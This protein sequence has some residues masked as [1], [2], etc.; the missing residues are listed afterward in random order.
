VIMMAVMK[1]GLKL[2]GVIGPPMNA[3]KPR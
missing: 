2:P 1:G 3:D